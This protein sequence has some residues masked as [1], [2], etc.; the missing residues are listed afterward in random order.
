[1]SMAYHR[2]QQHLLKNCLQNQDQNIQLIDCREESEWKDGHMEMAQWAPLSDLSSYIKEM[3]K[4]RPIFVYC[5][6]GGR[7]LKATAFL[8]EQ[9]FHVYSIEGGYVHLKEQHVIT[10][11][12]IS[13]E[14]TNLPMAFLLFF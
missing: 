9:G 13:N 11:H 2:F 4:K 1:M 8:Q 12:T 14:S 10:S 7:S 5:R 3:D 6:R